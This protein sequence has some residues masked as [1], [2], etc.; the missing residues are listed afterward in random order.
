MNPNPFGPSVETLPR[1]GE[2]RFRW[3]GVTVGILLSDGSASVF[4]AH[5]E[6]T[7][8]DRNSR[9]TDDEAVARALPAW[10]DV[11][12]E[13][14]EPKWGR[15]VNSNGIFV[16]ELDPGQEQCSR[17]EVVLLW[18]EVVVND[19]SSYDPETG[20]FSRYVIAT[21]DAVQGNVMSFFPAW[22]VIHQARGAEPGQAARPGRSDAFEPGQAEALQAGGVSL[23][24]GSLNLPAVL[25]ASPSP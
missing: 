17:D 14:L 11:S 19:N 20:K 7:N 22:K 21:V 16:S 1:R 3:E 6:I 24:P 4:I 15:P 2:V 23:T 5:P 13:F 10:P 25:R 9:H 12:L 8:P 18:Q